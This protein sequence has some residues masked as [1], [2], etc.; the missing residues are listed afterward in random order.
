MIVYRPLP[1]LKV[2]N[3][4]NHPHRLKGELMKYNLNST[5]DVTSSDLLVL[6]VF[7]EEKEL[8]FSSAWDKS[9]KEFFGG[10]NTC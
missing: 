8:K 9:L 4:L 1:G 7:N 10:S 3:Y 6:P 2:S 5:K